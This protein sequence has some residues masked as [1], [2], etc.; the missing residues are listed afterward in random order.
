MTNTKINA[1]PQDRTGTFLQEF[2]APVRAV[3]SVMMRENAVASSVMILDQNATH[4]EV[5]AVGG[6]IAIRWV[7][8]TETPTVAP[9]ASVIASG[10][11]ANFD[12]II[13]SG[14]YRR[15]A[16]P[17]ETGG[18]GPQG[19]ANAG[20]GSVYGLYQRLAQINVG[21]PPASVLIVQY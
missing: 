14:T 15:F 10:L 7:P 3:A 2:A 4:V 21:T 5:N 16:I 19:I 20:L 12:H 1:L 9:R 17:K 6:G 8:A 18:V 11:G 13:P